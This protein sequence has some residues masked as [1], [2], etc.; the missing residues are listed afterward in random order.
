MFAARQGFYPP[1][2]ATGGYGNSAFWSASSTTNFRLSS[3][4]DTN[5]INWKATSGYTIEYWFYNANASWP[6]TINPGP[7]NHDGGGTNY[8]SF[9][10]SNTGRIEFYYW[11]PGTNYVTTADNVVTLNSWNYIAA[12]TTSVGTTT[13]MSIYVNGTR[14]QVRAATSSGGGTLGNTVT[15]TNTWQGSTGTPFLMGAYSS[16]KWTNFFFD[17][18]RVSNT[19]RYSGASHTV[20][21]SPFTSDAN[22]QLLMICDGANGSTT[23]TD[24]SG[25]ARTITNQSNLVTISSARANHS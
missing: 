8:W 24:S 14:V 7:G 23:F 22:T 4:R 2:I 15:L 3:T 20:P 25:F 17:N 13:T 5:L 12:V 9:G 21:T 10:P 19:A 18:L 6:G 1:A 16:N 11:A